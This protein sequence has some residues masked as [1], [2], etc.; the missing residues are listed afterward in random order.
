MDL[1]WLMNQP[2]VAVIGI[3]G[4]IEAIQ[5]FQ[6][7]SGLKLTQ[8]GD[9]FKSADGKL[10]ILNRN[11]FHADAFEEN[12]ASCVWDRAA[13]V[14]ISP[15]DREKYVETMKRIIDTKKRFN[16][17]LNV[18]EYDTR[19]VE[20][21]PHLVTETEVENLFG[22]FCSIRKLSEKLVPPTSTEYFIE[23]PFIEANIDCTEVVYL[24]TN[25][26]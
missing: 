6:S 10:K 9:Q 26:S 19:K 3:E 22:N 11:L 20:G 14:A 8:S 13:L 24:L 16:Y 21:P 12:S 7:S 4:V 23:Q 18:V 2:D 5:A 1:I 17:L 25:K 15:K